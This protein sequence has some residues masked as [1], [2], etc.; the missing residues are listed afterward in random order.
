MIKVLVKLVLAL[1][2]V[3]LA[4]RIA[5]AVQKAIKDPAEY[6]AYV[7][8]LNMQDPVQKGAAM[9]AFFAKYPASV[10]KIDALEQA[11]AAYQQSG[12]QAKVEQMA[13]VILQNDPDHVRALAVVTYIQRFKATQGDYEALKKVRANGEKGLD[14]VKKWPKPEGISDADFEKLRNQMTEIFSGAV[15]FGAL[16]VK[17]YA[18]A[19]KYYLQSVRIDP[20]NLQ[21][22]YQLGIAYLEMNPINIA[23]FWYIAK[24]ISLTQA[25]NNGAAAQSIGQY[26]KAKYKK[27]HGSEQGWDEMLAS[28][29]KQV[30]PPVGFTVKAAPT[31]CEIAVQAVEQNDP[32]TLSFSDWEFI[33][34]HRDC[35]AEAGKAAQTVWQAI[36]D[37]QKQGAAKLQIPVK[38][39]SATRE[40]ISAAI[41]DENRENNKVDLEI[42]MEKPIP[43]A[44]APGSEIKIIGVLV[45]YTPKP[46]T[47][48]MTQGEVR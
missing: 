16:Q 27:Y 39:I 14:A 22:V 37:K 35:S 34:A 20:T 46:F 1:V 24:A 17:D 44:P 26:G 5:S 30:S 3:M 38:V 12:N 31:E 7:S 10:V 4:W 25:Q 42:I 11:M 29:A 18:R 36:Q 32:S 2:I 23:G 8:A 40:H 9:E 41:T 47:F 19:S 48:K 13:N 33:L 28:V 45:G 21:D 43:E 15:A 6:D